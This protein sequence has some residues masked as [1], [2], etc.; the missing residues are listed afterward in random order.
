[1][2][3]NDIEDLGGGSFRTTAS[4]QRYSRLDQYAMGLV[5]ESDVPPFFYVESPVNVVP[6]R[7]PEDAPRVGVTFN[8]TRRDVLLQDVIAVEGPRVP[9][10]AGSPRVHRQAFIYLVSAGRSPDGGQ[11]DKTDRIRRQ[12]ETFFQQATDG[13]MQADTRLR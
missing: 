8:G 1:M 9:D 2:E 5:S 13:R 4:V 3:G 12:W 10:A 7:G 6:N 11:I